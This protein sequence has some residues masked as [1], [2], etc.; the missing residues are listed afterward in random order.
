MLECSFHRRGHWLPMKGICTRSPSKRV[1]GLG[2]EPRTPLTENLRSFILSFIL[3]S[4]QAHDKCRH[5]RSFRKSSCGKRKHSETPVCPGSVES[6]GRAQGGMRAQRRPRTPL[7]FRSAGPQ[8]QLGG[9]ERLEP[10]LKR[11]GEV[12]RGRPRIGPTWK[13]NR[14]KCCFLFLVFKEISIK[15]LTEHKLEEQRF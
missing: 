4:V 7:A 3:K 15:T 6:R 12:P 5:K 14:W 8:V 10:S 2:F 9:R 1:A 13:N 11:R